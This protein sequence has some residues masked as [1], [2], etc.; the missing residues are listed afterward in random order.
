MKQ[1]KEN[2]AKMRKGIQRE[3]VFADIALIVLGLIMTVFPDKSGDIICIV[4]G[5]ILGIWGILRL[6]S[7]FTSDK[8]DAFGS[9]ALVQGSALLGFGVL[10]IVKPEF[11]AGLLLSALAIILII[12]G[13]MKLQYAV[14]F[15]RIKARFWWIS[16]IGALL[17]IVLGIIVFFNLSAVA[18]W[19]MIFIGVSFLVCGIWDL[20]S[21]ALLSRLAK[22]FQQEITVEVEADSVVDEDIY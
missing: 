6:V 2:N 12:G 11:L 9:F 19:L 8:V 4:I 20:I 14:D 10:F 21:V 17:S 7:Y 3:L 18:T 15:L 22:K 16:L 5:I 13:V 1:K